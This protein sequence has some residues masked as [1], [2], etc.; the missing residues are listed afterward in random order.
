MAFP[1]MAGDIGQVIVRMPLANVTFIDD[2]SGSKGSVTDRV[3]EP[4]ERS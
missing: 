2:G 1:F 3:K 4:N